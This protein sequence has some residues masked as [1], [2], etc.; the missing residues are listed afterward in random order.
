MGAKDK[1]KILVKFWAEKEVNAYS[2]NAAR[3]QVVDMKNI[4]AEKGITTM[5]Y[6]DVIGEGI[7]LNIPAIIT[8]SLGIGYAFI[9]FGVFEY[10]QTFAETDPASF[11]I[12]IF[13]WILL[14]LRTYRFPESVSRHFKQR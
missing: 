10:I 11:L 5:G 1:R 9:M 14:L 3:R 12:A 2:L 7:L 6:M 4:K 13:A 8:M